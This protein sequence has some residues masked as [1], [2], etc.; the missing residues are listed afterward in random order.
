MDSLL[1][2][3]GW[4]A[5]NNACEAVLLIDSEGNLKAKRYPPTYIRLGAD[6]RQG[7]HEENLWLLE[8]GLPYGWLESD[9]V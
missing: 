1:L 2:C 9:Y 7:Y 8:G 3:Q 4:P 5:V 6:E